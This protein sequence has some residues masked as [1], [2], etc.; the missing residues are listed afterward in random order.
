MLCRSLKFQT[1][2]LSLKSISW[3]KMV[4]LSC[5]VRIKSIKQEES[6]SNVFIKWNCLHTKKWSKYTFLLNDYEIA[7]NYK[8]FSPLLHAYSVS[9]FTKPNLEYHI[10][11]N[12]IYRIVIFL[13]VWIKPQRYK[14]MLNYF[15]SMCKISCLFVY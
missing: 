1:D 4:F 5:W 15:F 10:T 6:Q 3:Y 9:H 8:N 13:F 7:C 12:T 14:E 11:G 2:V